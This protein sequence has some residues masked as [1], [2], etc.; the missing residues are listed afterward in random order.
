VITGDMPGELAAAL[1]GL[2]ATA[3]PS[4]RLA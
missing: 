1:N 3:S 4:C 2:G